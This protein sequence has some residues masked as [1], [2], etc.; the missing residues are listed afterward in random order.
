MTPM[1]HFIGTEESSCRWLMCTELG[2][3]ILPAAEMIFSADATASANTLLH[4]IKMLFI[5]RF[6]SARGDRDG[7]QL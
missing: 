2:M 4:G 5:P 1:G 7:F 6:T 3:S